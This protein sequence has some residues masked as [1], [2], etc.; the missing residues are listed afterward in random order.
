MRRAAAALALASFATSGLAQEVAPPVAIAAPPHV[1][2]SIYVPV[3]DGTRLAMNI[4]QPAMDGVATPGRKPVI[5]AFTPYRARFRNADGKIV[6]T[7]LTPRTS[8]VG[9]LRAGYVVAVADIR[10]KGA[11]FGTRRGFQDRTEALD[12]RDLIEWLAKQP[13]STGKVGM[14]G[15]S[16][17]GGTTFQVATTTPPSLKAVFVG[18]SEI[19]KYGFVRRGGITAQFNTR[20]DEPLSDDLM[21]LPVDGDDGTLLKAAVAQHA[22]NT[23]MGPLWYGM[24]YR[25]SVSPLTGNPFWNEVA[26]YT[27]VGAIKKAGIA[28]YFWS[29]WRDEP[30]AQVLQAAAT[31]G[32]KF[33]AAP[34]GHCNPPDDFDLQ[35]EVV[36]YFDHY[37]KGVDNGIEREPRATYAVEGRPAAQKWVRS[38]ALP[39]V[40]EPHRTY[41]L[42]AAGTLDTRPGAA[43][44]RH[45]TTDYTL[46]PAEQFAFWVTPQGE[47][48][49]N[50]TGAALP[51]PMTSIGYPVID[52]IAS[53]D[54]TDAPLF[55]YL[56]VVAADGS[57]D[58]VSFG[59]LSAAQ[60]KEAKA[61]Y[62]TLGTPWNSGLKTDARPMVPGKPA[63]LRFALTPISRVIQAGARLR[64]ALTGADPRQRNLQQIRQTPA[65][66]WTI[67]S[68]TLDLPAR[69][70]R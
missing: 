35:G 4:Y 34:G 24:P 19:D 42:T 5:F 6:E 11:S 3:R 14:M 21:S 61:P 28:T 41:Y 57:A 40:G 51:A 63:Q 70:D 65:P 15:C 49:L 59:R 52:V 31:L 32:G 64:V 45:F 29:N 17:L 58:V 22:G 68:A 66:G 25:D 18:A 67:H 10:G 26:V 8:I 56:E 46:P 2:T 53:V 7:A 23:P 13:F 38:N 39:G 33:I 27:Y 43:G 60:R 37:L 48:G 20:A 47:H 16:Y 69:M 55:A 12:G 36:R 9:L 50:W 44:T 62:D 1:R 54:K 30:T